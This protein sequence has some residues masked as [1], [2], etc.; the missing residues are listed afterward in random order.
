MAESLVHRDKPA[1]ELRDIEKYYLQLCGP[2]V[3]PVWYF[4]GPNSEISYI[5]RLN[6]KRI[7]STPEAYNKIASTVTQYLPLHTVSA[8]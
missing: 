7:K 3:N 5:T 8:S 1:K 4:D 2:Q 6:I